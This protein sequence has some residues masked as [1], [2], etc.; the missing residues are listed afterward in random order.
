MTS[1]H[2]SNPKQPRHTA[3]L[4]PCVAGSTPAGGTTSNDRH[5]TSNSEGSGDGSTPAALEHSAGGPL[6]SSYRPWAGRR[7]WKSGCPV[8]QRQ[9]A[10]MLA[11]FLKLTVLSSVKWPLS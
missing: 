6:A 2:N 1:A 5:D 4:K 3:F 9:K 10:N 8:C 11:T 7:G